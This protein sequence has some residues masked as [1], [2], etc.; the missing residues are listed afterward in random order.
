MPR[1]LMM[2][3][4][5]EGNFGQEIGPARSRLA[6]EIAEKALVRVVLHYGSKPE[7]V[8]LG[9]L[10]P[11]WLCGESASEIR[12]AGTI[13]VDVQVDLEIACGAINSRQLER[14]LRS[15]GFVPK[16]DQGW[17]WIP[18]TD[19]S[20]ASAVKFDLLADYGGA[21]TKNA[22]KFDGCE[23]LGAFNLRGTGFASRDI[24]VRRLSAQIDGVDHHVDVNVS[25]LA[26]FLLTKIAAA[27]EERRSKDWYDIA[28]VLLHNDAGGPRN[29]AELVREHFANEISEV[30]SAIN[31]LHE[32]FTTPSA[33]GTDA[34]VQEMRV[35]YPE[36][37]PKTL[38]ADAVLA[39]EE[40]YRG[41]QN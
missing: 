7:F 24:D 27:Y 17:C 22:I 36:L 25:G 15:A 18:A 13:D 6:R 10:V 12:H 5:L 16:D 19:G 31:D 21:A 39:V 40:F 41:L 33:Q 23:S 8:V 26:G 30:R 3:R 35:S 14:A 20:A 11:E 9:G 2:S 28:F 38:A 29:A 32:N 34:Y 1:I 4:S 37:D